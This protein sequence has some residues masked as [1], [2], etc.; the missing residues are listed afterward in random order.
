MTKL[1]SWT[2]KRSYAYGTALHVTRGGFGQNV[3]ADVICADG[4]LRRTNHL[5]AHADTFFSTG[6]SVKVRGHNI[7]GFITMSTKSGLSTATPD[8]PAFLTF[9][10]HTFHKWSH[11]LSE[12]ESQCRTAFDDAAL[13]HQALESYLAKLSP[14]QR[15]AYLAKRNDPHH[16]W[17]KGD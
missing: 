5:S 14:E 8:D 1:E 17:A 4:K 16:V 15:T 13:S 9:H 10:A 2:C 11:L 12:V 7:T 6:A 3:A